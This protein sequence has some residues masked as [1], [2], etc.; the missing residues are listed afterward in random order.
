VGALA[1]VYAALGDRDRAIPLLEQAA[2]AYDP[3]IL[4]LKVDP[5]LDKLRGDP[6]FAKLLAT[7]G[8]AK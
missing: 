5:R 1:T 4:R 2:R 6:R 7:V 8:L 3:V